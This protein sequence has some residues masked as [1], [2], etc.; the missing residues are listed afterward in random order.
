VINNLNF[1]E[2]IINPELIDGIDIDLSVFEG[3]EN[4]KGYKDFILNNYN[5]KLITFGKEFL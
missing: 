1:N 2:S 5:E 3:L 4:E